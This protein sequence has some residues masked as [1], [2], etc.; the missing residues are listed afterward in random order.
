MALR[1]ERVLGKKRILELYLNQIYLGR[2]AYESGAA[3]MR[4]FNVP[5]SKLNYA[6]IAYLAALPKAPTITPLEKQ[7]EQ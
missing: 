6:Q 5:P 3:S 2:G 7:N 4:Y 1:I